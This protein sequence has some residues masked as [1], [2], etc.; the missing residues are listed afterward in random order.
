MNTESIYSHML[1]ANYVIGILFNYIF[2]A[3]YTKHIGY[4][5]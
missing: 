1:P 4:G 2:Y 3:N 5:F